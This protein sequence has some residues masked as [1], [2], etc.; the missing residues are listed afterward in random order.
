MASSLFGQNNNTMNLINQFAEFKKQFNGNPK[1]MVEELLKSGKMTEE[2]FN[3]LKAVADQ[4]Q[5]I[6]K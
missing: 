1:T 3:Q 2:Q 5:G 6:L 4:L